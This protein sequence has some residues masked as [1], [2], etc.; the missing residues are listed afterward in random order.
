MILNEG[1]PFRL[2]LVLT[3]IVAACLLPC[4]LASAQAGDGGYRT[5]EAGQI[6]RDAN[7][8]TLGPSDPV[9]AP[10]DADRNFSPNDP[11]EDAAPP[12]AQNTGPVRLARFAFVSGNVTWR[13]DEKDEWSKATVNLPIRQGAQV[14]VTDD[15][16]ADLQFDDG[17]ELRLGHGALATLKVLY[18]DKDG[19][20]TQ[21]ALNDGLATLHSRHDNAIY[22]IDTP[23][24]SVKSKGASQVRFGV[25]G[26][27]EVTVQHGDATIEGPQ[28]TTALHAG[29]YLYLADS[30]AP[31]T[32]K[33][34]PAADNW[35][36]WNDERNRVLEGGAN[37]HVPSNI[38]LVAG[39][40]DQYGTWRNDP[41]NGWVWCP[42]GVSSDWRPYS[43][44]RWTWV[45]PFGWTWVSNEPWGW[46]PFHYGT[47]VHLS[48]GWGWCPGPLHQYWSPGVVHFSEYDGCVAWAPLCP[49]E[50]HYPS[51]LSFA[52]WGP[53]WGFSFS[54]GS[55][56]VYYPFGGYC[57][58][59][60]FGNR[61][62]NRFDRFRDVNFRR[63]GLSPSFDRFAR[64]NEFAAANRHFVP[65][66]GSHVAG[67]S[68]ARKEAF[69]GQGRYQ[70][71]STAN[72]A[73]FSRGRFAAAPA[74]GRTPVQG[75]PAIMP[76][77]IGRTPT[78]SFVA[79]ARPSPS[80]LNRNIY[81]AP[82][83]IGARGAGGLAAGRGGSTAVSPSLGARGSS[84]GTSRIGTDEGRV[85]PG[86]T[87][88]GRLHSSGGQ[89]G[90]ATNRPGAADGSRAGAFG[91]RSSASDTARTSGFGNRS[92]AGD[93]ARYGG[94]G[95]RSS[96]LGGASSAAEAARRARASLGMGGAGSGSY[97]GRNAGSADSGRV[98]RSDTSRNGSID[99][100]PR[101]GGNGSY[102]STGRDSSVDRTPRSSGSTGRTYDQGGR[103]G[104]TG[105]EAAPRSDSGGRSSYHT[106]G[107]YGYGGY[108]SG[109]SRSYGGDYGSSRSGN[110]YGTGG[111]SSGRSGSYSGAE[112]RSSGY[113]S[114]RSSGDSGSGRYSAPSSGRS[115]GGS[116][117][118]GRSSGG[119]SGGGGR[120]GGAQR[121]GGGVD[122]GGRG[123]GR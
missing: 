89:S 112:G 80:V 4:A 93:T 64:T 32:V 8:H 121:S 9:G 120:S 41:A 29:D 81:H 88:G 28:G 37:S 100:A 110:S 33:P 71:L 101:T 49:W 92:S 76:T 18:S 98:G 116:S 95:N 78:R 97:S 35:D 102:G 60:P 23:A 56:G 51:A 73:Y 86:S 106:G 7:G 96:A 16:H 30:N 103:S 75:P 6:E 111:Y 44:G 22:Q 61:F 54:I 113:S 47:W 38:G 122:G 10:V 5:G 26:G 40:L 91:S 34:A 107:D 43:D 31:F 105:R 45:D 27:S 13:A 2:P 19:E 59:R 46:A 14:W 117:G 3:G 72:S 115:Y 74:A 17:S 11:I 108:S 114:G 119:S 65:F 67:A 24:A 87:A 25:D 118:G 52:F 70:P 48:Y 53:R 104:S 1:A 58:G 57:V 50:V 21:I 15:G 68:F 66:N 109:R 94:F 85:R 42:R 84:S 36:Q 69:G 123:R 63:G 90:I 79:N 39:D 55:C 83:Q 20:F 12:E 62:V 99:R 82:T 77:A